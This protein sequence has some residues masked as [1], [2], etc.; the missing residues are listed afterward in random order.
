MIICG[1]DPIQVAGHII[2]SYHS[3]LPLTKSEYYGL[4]KAALARLFQVIVLSEYEHYCS[5]DNDYVMF[6]YDEYWSLLRLLWL[7]SEESVYRTLD[8]IVNCTF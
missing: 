4:Y 2:A 3:V 6:H 7:T 8:R 1:D 5:P